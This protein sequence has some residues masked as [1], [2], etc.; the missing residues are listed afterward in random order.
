MSAHFVYKN[1][2][3]CAEA[4]P[5]AAMATAYGTPFYCYSSAALR[6]NYEELASALAD[7]QPLICFAVKA[8]GNV[9]VIGSF[10][11][12]GAG[13]D[14]VSVG[15]MRRALAAGVPADKIIFSGVGKTHDEILAAATAGIYQFNVES[16]PELAAIEAVG[17][18]LG[19]K[20]PIALRVNPDVDPRTHAKIST[21]QKTAK[22]G[23]NISH[24]P[25]A[26]VAIQASPHLDFCGIAVHIGSQL[27]ELA[28]FDQAFGVVAA[29]I[30]DLR[31]HGHAISRIDLGGGLGIVYNNETPPSPVAYAAIVRKH[32]AALGLKIALEPGRSLVGT[33]GVLVSKVIY[34][35]TGED[36][37]FLIIDAAMN[38]LIRPAMYDSWHT[39]LPVRESVAEA[40]PRWEV[41]GPI[42]E[43]SDTFGHDRLLGAVA[44]ADLVAITCAGAYGASMSSTYNARTLIP[45][46]LVDSDRFALIRRG[47][48]IEEQISWDVKP[49]WNHS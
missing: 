35:K 24:I 27:T 28:P 29:L 47:V 48:P 13:A 45:E 25:A 4:V 38:D 11:A 21:G 22:F 30:T 12:L 15:E 6:Q 10:A 5:L 37:N 17:Q 34:A 20:I 46:V 3:L 36:K 26:L 1:G 7:M 31:A 16:V 8:N 9:S 44:P 19:K 43:T 32:F 49:E 33:A 40:S 39:I 14:V 42:C 2:V 41:V 23:I 18:Q